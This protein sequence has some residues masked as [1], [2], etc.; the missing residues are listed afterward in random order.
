[1]PA[2]TGRLLA[3]EDDNAPLALPDGVR[4][5]LERPAVEAGWRLDAVAGRF[6]EVSAA[7]AGAPL[8]LV[9]RLILDAQ[10]LSKPQIYFR[11]VAW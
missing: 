1:M 6:V 8:T 11:A 4:R 10:A 3:W 7:A 5:G 9:F 2:E